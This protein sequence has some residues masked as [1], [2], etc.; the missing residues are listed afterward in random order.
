MRLDRSMGTITKEVVRLRA[1][2]HGNATEIFGC[3]IWSNYKGGMRGYHSIYVK[4]QN[5]RVSDTPFLF[6]QIAC[7]I[8]REFWLYSTQTVSALVESSSGGVS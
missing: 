6:D 7:I 4:A 2:F 1:L 3:E 8:S 5:T